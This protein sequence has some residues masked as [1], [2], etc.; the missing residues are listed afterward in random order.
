VDHAPLPALVR[1][2]LDNHHSWERQKF[3]EIRG[4]SDHVL[5]EPGDDFLE[6]R[7]LRDIF[8]GMSKGF[9]AHMKREEQEL[10]PT[11]LHEVAPGAGEAQRAQKAQTLLPL[12]TVLTREHDVLLSQW[13]AMKALT[14]RYT[15]SEK[16][17]ENHRSLLKELRELEIYQHQHIHK[18]N[19]VLF[20]KIRVI[21]QGAG[22]ASP[23]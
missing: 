13:D 10:F 17:D 7:Q 6:L 8:E 14:G 19:F 11:F 12:L 9:L 23:Q 22:E 5:K 3:L 21:A 16:A 1:F 18:E 20:E 15:P 4:Q 2:I